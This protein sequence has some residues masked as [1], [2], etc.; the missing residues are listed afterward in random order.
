MTADKWGKV[1]C[2]LYDVSVRGTSSKDKLADLADDAE[3]WS[4]IVV[5]VFATPP[6]SLE[7]AIA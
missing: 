1:L 3:A 2:D 4:D 5:V 6:F 7:T